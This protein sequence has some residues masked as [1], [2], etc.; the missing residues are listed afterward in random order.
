MSSKSAYKAVVGKKI[1]D[2]SQ[3]KNIVDF[4][5]VLR[6]IFSILYNYW[7]DHFIPGGRCLDQFLSRWKYVL[8][9]T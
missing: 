1:E 6:G 3:K 5:I 4:Y 9:L 2:E 7:M 8:T